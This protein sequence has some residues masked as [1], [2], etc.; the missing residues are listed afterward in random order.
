M[1]M[2]HLTKYLLDLAEELR[3]L[4]ETAEEGAKDSLLELARSYD[5]LAM[6]GQVAGLVN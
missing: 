1:N 6:A 2:D 4:A 5:V 3:R